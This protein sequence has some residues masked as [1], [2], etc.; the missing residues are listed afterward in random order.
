MFAA[1][2]QNDNSYELILKSLIK[3]LI[4]KPCAGLLSA[5]GT[6]LIFFHCSSKFVM[7]LVFN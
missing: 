6:I 5:L 4:L 2:D 1:E 7:D 3:S